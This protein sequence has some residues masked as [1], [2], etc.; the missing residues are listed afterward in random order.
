MHQDLSP[1]NDLAA[2]ISRLVAAVS[3]DRILLFGSRATGTA[4][5]DS[6]IDLLVVLPE[7]VT[8]DARRRAWHAVSFSETPVDLVIVSAGF[9]E[10]FRDVV[11]TF[12][13]EAVHH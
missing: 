11:G 8:T 1:G 5:P 13:Y 3:P 7:A 2:L 9:V 4:R 6:D 12:A 10:R